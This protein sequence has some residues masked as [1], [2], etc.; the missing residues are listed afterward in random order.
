MVLKNRHIK[1]HN[2]G[3]STDVEYPLLQINS[4]KFEVNQTN[5]FNVFA[6][7]SRR[8]DRQKGRTKCVLL[9][10]MNRTGVTY[11]IQL[12]E[13]QDFI[14]YYVV[15]VYVHRRKKTAWHW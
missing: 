8:T 1:G 12:T 6:F 14:K 2:F 4:V 10:D 9:H 7:T 5:D 13:F 15:H 11:K 3:Q